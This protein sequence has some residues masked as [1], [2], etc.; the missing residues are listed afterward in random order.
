MLKTRSLFYLGKAGDRRLYAVSGWEVLH[1]IN[2]PTPTVEAYDVVQDTWHFVC[3]LDSAMGEHS[4]KTSGVAA[5]QS[6]FKGV[7]V[8]K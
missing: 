4:G 3:S 5:L 1:D 8:G 7:P 6:S 2:G